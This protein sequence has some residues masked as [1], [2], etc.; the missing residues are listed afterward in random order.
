MKCV[1]P[2]PV[3]SIC[4]CVLFVAFYPHHAPHHHHHQPPHNDLSASASLNQ[5]SLLTFHSTVL[6]EHTNSVFANSSISCHTTPRA[7]VSL[8]HAHASFPFLSPISPRPPP[9][10]ARLI[11]EQGDL[12][13][14]GIGHGGLAIRTK[15]C[16]Q[17]RTR[18]PI[19]SAYARHID[20]ANSTHKTQ[21]TFA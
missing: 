16:G 20:E 11:G 12:G 1:L 17:S 10:H 5:L 9:A 6:H 3:H 4:V 19:G 18:G 7:L 2:D 14:S 13:G 21:S 15:K 8:K